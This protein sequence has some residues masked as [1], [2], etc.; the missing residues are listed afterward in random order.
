MGR[1]VGSLLAIR[2]A[3]NAFCDNHHLAVEDKTAMEAAQQLISIARSGESGVEMLLSRVEE[4]F[5]ERQADITALEIQ[6]DNSNQAGA[7]SPMAAGD[8]KSA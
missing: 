2:K 6:A 5:S 8:Q 3:L 4:W 7:V 1:G